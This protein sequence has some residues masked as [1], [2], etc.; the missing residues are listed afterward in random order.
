M[1]FY[2]SPDEGYNRQEAEKNTRD[3]FRN[4]E[5]V[6]VISEKQEKIDELTR[7]L[8]ALGNCMLPEDYGKFIERS[9]CISL[10]GKDFDIQICKFI[11]WFK[12]HCKFD[13]ER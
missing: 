7:M 1:P 6:R 2:S 12:L 4:F 13:K 3:C 9:K 11:E 10:S 8:C 5:V